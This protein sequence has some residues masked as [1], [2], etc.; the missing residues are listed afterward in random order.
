M[1]LLKQLNAEDKLKRPVMK[2][3]CQKKP[4]YPFGYPAVDDYSS[5]SANV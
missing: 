1:F 2:Y 5:I 4:G 3:L